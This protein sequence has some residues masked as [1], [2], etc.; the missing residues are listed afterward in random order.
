MI[1]RPGRLPDR[2]T[3][4]FQPDRD[5]GKLGSDRLMFDE[6][7]P[8]LHAQVRK[9]ECSFVRCTTYSEVQRLVQR[10]SV[11]Q[12]IG[13]SQQRGRIVAEKIAG[14]HSAI[15]EGDIATTT[16]RPWFLVCSY[17]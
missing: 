9:I 5:F 10:H 16:M 3:S 14:R 1:R 11:A 17:D 6:R 4:D 12:D 2:G 7:S 13:A 8:S 15:F